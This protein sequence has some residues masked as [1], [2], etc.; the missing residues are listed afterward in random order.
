MRLIRIL[1]NT[2]VNITMVKRKKRESTKTAR[3]M[4]NGLY[5]MRMVRNGMREI[6]KTAN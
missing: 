4:A 2:Y 1:V 6:T 5:G 3:K